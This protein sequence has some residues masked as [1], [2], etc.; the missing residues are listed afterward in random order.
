MSGKAIEY[1]DKTAADY[2]SFTRISCDDFHYGPLLPGERQLSL[3]LDRLKPGMTALELGSGAGQNSIFLAKSGL[4]CTALDGAPGQ[5]EQGIALAARHGVEVDFRLCDLDEFTADEGFSSAFDLVHSVF[6]LPFLADGKMFVESAAKCLK[7]G[8]TFVLATAHP[9]FTGDWV[10]MDD[11]GVGVFIEDYFN[12]PADERHTEGGDFA[13]SRP[14]PIST[15]C[16]WCREAG[17]SV[18]RLLEP[19]PV[20]LDGMSKEEIQATVP[21]DSEGWRELVGIMQRIPVA[22][23]MVARKM[24]SKKCGT[25]K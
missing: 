2:Q 14:V 13:A 9:L 3:F 10:E 1:W 20:G 22:V 7:L 24:E 5:T 17:L 8:G 21:Y 15:L 6:T 18:E 11:G 23:V 19:K 4:I 25:E 12:P 16:E